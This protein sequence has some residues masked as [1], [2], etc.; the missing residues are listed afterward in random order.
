VTTEIT[1][2]PQLT[3]EGL[4]LA[5][6]RRAA[7]VSRMARAVAELEER[8][9]RGDCTSGCRS[10]THLAQHHLHSGS[11]SVKRARWSRQRCYQLCTRA[12]I[13]FPITCGTPITAPAPKPQRGHRYRWILSQRLPRQ[14]AS[15]CPRPPGHPPA[16]PPAI[17]CSGSGT[18]DLGNALRAADRATGEAHNKAREDRSVRRTPPRLLIAWMGRSFFG[19]A[20]IAGACELRV[21]GG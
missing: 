1:S 9:P 20:N 5:L 12:L 6:A 17:S 19:A 14:S 4:P 15:S 2:L 13:A 16:L 10:R 3:P 18:R 21:P 7:Q 11:G 8:G